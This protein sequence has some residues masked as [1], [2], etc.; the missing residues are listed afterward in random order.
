MRDT[1]RLVAY[2]IRARGPQD[3]FYRVLAGSDAVAS[4]PSWWQTRMA[5][6][7]PLPTPTP[8]PTDHLTPAERHLLAQLR[9]LVPA[10]MGGDEP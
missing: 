10:L 3:C 6:A 1:A 7:P 2:A 5:S 4:M 8:A 9:S